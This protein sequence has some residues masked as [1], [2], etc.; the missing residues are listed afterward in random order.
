MSEH[1]ANC[2]VSEKLSA[3]CTCGGDLS[4]VEELIAQAV[5]ENAR[6]QFAYVHVSREIIKALNKAGFVVVPREPTEK[7]G[8]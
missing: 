5:R 6:G 8:R 1:K 2:E 7:D 4:Q 3:T